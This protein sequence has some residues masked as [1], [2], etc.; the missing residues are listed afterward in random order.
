MI[1]LRYAQVEA[2]PDII[3]VLHVLDAMRVYRH[4]AVDLE[5]SLLLY[6]LVLSIIGHLRKQLFK[7]GIA[8]GVLSNVLRVCDQL[9]ELSLFF[10]PKLV[11]VFFDE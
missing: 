7:M 6:H 4:S 8:L 9:V 10:P 11:A 5:E 1:V 3:T 2:Q